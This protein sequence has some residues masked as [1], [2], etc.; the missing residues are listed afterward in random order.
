MLAC[1]AP[2][3][4]ARYGASLDAV[5][6]EDFATPDSVFQIGVEPHRVDVL[7][8]IE[9]VTFDEAWPERL[10]MRIDGLDVLVL[11]RRQLIAKKR[12]VGRPQDLADVARLERG[13]RRR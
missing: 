3:P 8:S 11:G 1:T 2:I 6:P 7:T 4:S 5:D 12:A 9:G 10:T 13:E